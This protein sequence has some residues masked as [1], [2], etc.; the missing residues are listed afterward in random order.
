VRFVCGAL[1]AE[2]L[3]V[4]LYMRIVYGALRAELCVLS[5]AYGAFAC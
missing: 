5:F 1:R 4:E 3:R 2:F